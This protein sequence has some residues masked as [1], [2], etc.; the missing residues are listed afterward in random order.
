M[1]ILA[2]SGRFEPSR[3][4]AK[5]PDC[6]R[7]IFLFK[8]QSEKYQVSKAVKPSPLKLLYVKKWMYFRDTGWPDRVLADCY[9]SG[10]VCAKNGSLPCCWQPSQ[11]FRRSG[12][13]SAT[14]QKRQKNFSEKPLGMRNISVWFPHIFHG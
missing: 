1:L 14:K 2:S 12:K 6:Q 4:Y 7:Q 3:R 8:L 13:N 11:V 9:T 10:S 5:L